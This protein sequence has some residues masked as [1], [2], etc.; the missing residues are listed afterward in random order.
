M[1]RKP[2][3][4]SSLRRAFGA[5]LALAL[6]VCVEVASAAVPVITRYRSPKNPDRRIRKS[7]SLI[8]LHTTEAAAKGSLRRLS[9]RGECHYCVTEDGTIYQ[10]VD[11]YRVA[12]HAGT[13][14]WNGKTDVDDFSVG[15]ECVG[16]HDKAMPL[17]QIKAI[18]ALVKELQSVYKLPDDRVVTHSMV[19]YGEANKW[20][21][22]KHRGR[23]RCGMLFA[24]PSVRK[25]LGLRT[26]AAFDPDTKA[27]RL[28]VGDPLLA[29]VLYGGMDTMAQ[30]Y[31]R[32]SV[33]GINPEKRGKTVVNTWSSPNVPAKP[34]PKPSQKPTPKPAPKPVAETKPA[35]AP[36]PVAE[37]KPAPPPKPGAPL[38]TFS[39]P[40][41]KTFSAPQPIVVETS[42]APQPPVEGKVA[43]TPP[44]P[45]APK[46][47]STKPSPPPASSRPTASFSLVP[48]SISELNNLGYVCVGMITK[49]RMPISIVGKEWNS[50]ATFYTIRGRVTPGNIMNPKRFEQGTG[51]WIRKATT[52]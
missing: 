36:K 42:P 48:Q 49:D 43:V 20:Q 31:G 12:F 2:F 3:G 52:P 8:V 7:T 9:E 19:A 35:P 46:P 5:I 15:I 18:R 17:V 27:R 38:K 44:K 1:T 21:K 47:P 24:M 50:P 30:T 41:P 14:M 45:D 23:K 10:I 11:R 33:V 32:G 29:K 16:Y 51:I 39:P 34:T 13:S 40:E 28:V 26:R 22:K 37:T 25:V 6:C 4:K